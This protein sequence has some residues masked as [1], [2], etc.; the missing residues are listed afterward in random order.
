MTLL[1]AYALVALLRA[2]PPAARVRELLRE[3]STA[4]TS[5]N[6]AETAYVLRRR[7]DVDRERVRSAVDTLTS[8]RLDVL[9]TGAEHG[10]RA[11]DLR[12]EHYHRQRCPL[13]LADCVLLASPG[14]GDRIAT[15]D[16]HV[17]RVAQIEGI[18]TVALAHSSG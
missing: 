17:L 9:S 6:L 4:I 18:A 12:A 2:E 10:W 16:S 1:D 14:S 13:S 5:I 7:Y 15:A 3:E 11:A 8:S